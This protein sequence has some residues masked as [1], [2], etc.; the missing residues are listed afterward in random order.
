MKTSHHHKSLDNLVVVVSCFHCA[1]PVVQP[2]RWSV[3]LFDEVQ[4]MC[5]VGCHAVT[6]AIIDAGLGDYYRYRTTPAELGSIPHDL[7]ARL[8]ELLVYDEPEISERYLHVVDANGLAMAGNAE[9]NTELNA[10]LN[11]GINADAIG[12]SSGDSRSGKTTEVN[13][14]VDGLRCG[15]CVWLLERSVLALPGVQMASFN[16]STARARVRFNPEQTPLSQILRR[17]AE[18]GYRG[19]PFDAVAREA[20]LN[21]ETRV[22]NQRLFVAGIA[23]M[24]VMMYALPAYL[25]N[26]GEIEQSHQQLLQWAGLVLTTPVMFYSAWPFLAGAWRDIRASNLGMDV[27]VSIGLIAAYSASV[28]ATVS[29]TG[30][31]YFDSVSMFV[32]LLLGARYIEWSVR[33][34]A[35]RAIDDISVQAPE[36]AQRIDGALSS[37]K[38]KIVTV[39]TARLRP[40]DEIT[41]DSGARIPVDGVVVDGLSEIDK[42]LLTGESIPQSIGVGDW[43]PGGA[44]LAGAPVRLLVE[45]PQ[46]ASTLSMIERLVDRGA[47]EKPRL[48]QTADR[49]ARV[50]VSTL[51]VFAFVVWIAWLYIDPTRAAD[52]AIVVLIVSCPCA[53]SLATPAALAAASGQLLQ[54]RLLITRGHALE[55]LSAVTDVVFDKTGTLTTGKLKI[56][57]IQCSSSMNAAAA[58]QLAAALEVGSAHPLARAIREAAT[59]NNNPGSDVTLHGLRHVAGFGVSAYTSADNELRLGSLHWCGLAAC[60]AGEP[61]VRADT[62]N[63]TS[64]EVYLSVTAA[65]SAPELLARF[66]LSDELRLESKALIAQLHRSGLQTHLLSGDRECVVANVACALSMGKYQSS[67]TPQGKQAYVTQLQNDG[68]VVLMIG[69][70]IND[71][72][73]LA[74]ANVSVAVGDASALTRTA[75]DVICLSAGL[76]GLLVLLD[77][78]RQTMRVVRQNLLWAISYNILAIPAAA[79]GLVPPWAAAIGMA[80]SSLLVVLNAVRLWKSSTPDHTKPFNQPDTVLWNRCSS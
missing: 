10:E 1:E 2:T 56:S 15:A 5:C 58:L 25:S 80:G 9:L 31:I 79:F 30:E 26:D 72:P 68:A 29:G 66:V 55:S 73:V 70:G 40:G 36:T 12:V 59:I 19:V 39:P 14:A 76:G 32:F 6:Q 38:P 24:Q 46:V 75:A 54:L 49:A 57:D 74:T 60:A 51:L 47:S 23:M 45:Q 78:A 13:L 27:P 48:V 37:G 67:T 64:S 18:V 16:F 20:A 7:A 42:S 65:G 41:V 69:D 17:I 61:G 21:R 33:R 28:R 62:G 4:P 63:D 77:K 43:V 34:K 52:I 44:L 71:A 50:F 11:K 53:L 22:L 3:E 35:I 8:D